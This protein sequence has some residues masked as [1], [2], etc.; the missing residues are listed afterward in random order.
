MRPGFGP[1]T[2]HNSALRRARARCRGELPHRRHAAGQAAD[3]DGRAA[4]R[5]DRHVVPH[6][7]RPPAPAARRHAPQ[8]QALS[9]RDRRSGLSRSS[10]LADDAHSRPR[11]DRRHCADRARARQTTGLSW[12]SAHDPIGRLASLGQQIHAN[13]RLKYAA[14]F[15][16]AALLLLFALLGLRALVDGGAGGAPRQPRPRRRTGV[17]RGSPHRRDHGRNRAPRVRAR[18]RLSQRRRAADA[19]RR[20]GLPLRG[21]D[22]FA[23]GVAGD[24]PVRPDAELAVLGDRQPGGDASPL[25]LLAGPFS[26]GGVSARS[27]SSSSASSVSS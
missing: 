9:G 20:R 1:T 12:A 23:A 14:L 4:D 6:V 8:R 7:H 16:I 18:A 21:G 3:R 26:R 27:A 22:G 17:E 19:L 10:R 15:I 24:Q 25:P 2:S 11:L 5:R 13:N